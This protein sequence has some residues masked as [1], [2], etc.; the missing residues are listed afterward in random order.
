MEQLGI[1]DADLIE[2]FT[3]ASGPGGQK[4]N[5][6]SSAVHLKHLP[7]GIEV[8]CRRERSQAANRFWA[9]M[10][11]CERIEARRREEEARR[12]SEREK[13]R[14][15]NRGRSRAAKERVLEAKHRQSVRKQRRKPVRE[16]E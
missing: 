12:R 15:R 6:T 7:S 2:S 4:V 10:E 16:G 13:K 3:L 14:R 8:K 1:R 5:K 11:L 9:R